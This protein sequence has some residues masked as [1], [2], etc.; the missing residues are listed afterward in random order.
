MTGTL[1][2]MLPLGPEQFWVSPKIFLLDVSL[3]LRFETPYEARERLSERGRRIILAVLD[4]SGATVYSVSPGTYF[5]GYPE[6]CDDEA[7]YRAPMVR[8]ILR[9]ALGAKAEVRL[10]VS[11]PGVREYEEPLRDPR[12]Y[13]GTCYLRSALSGYVRFLDYDLWCRH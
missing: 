8:R 9:E 4:E 10:R 13:L 6:L 2:T 7:V 3:R 1:F 5:F 12:A 11:G